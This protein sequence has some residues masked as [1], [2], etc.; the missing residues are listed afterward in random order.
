MQGGMA[1]GKPCHRIEPRVQDVSGAAQLAGRWHA[2]PT[3]AAGAAVGIA[4]QDIAGQDYALSAGA[5]LAAYQLLPLPAG[6]AM[7][8]SECGGHSLSAHAVPVP[9]G[10]PGCT[11]TA[12][13]PCMLLHAKSVVPHVGGRATAG[14]SFQA[15]PWP[16]YTMPCGMSLHRCR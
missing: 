14:P 1:A 6:R 10:H 3:W 4:L 5:V 9:L 11:D 13:Q 15:L 12:E 2:V 8:C 7:P 16:G